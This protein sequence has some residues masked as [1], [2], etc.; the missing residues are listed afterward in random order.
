MTETDRY[1]IISIGVD[2][3]LFGYSS[4]EF[5]RERLDQRLT[6]SQLSSLVAMET[7]LVVG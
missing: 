5:F 4:E 3:Q 7:P 2:E 6:P 1:C